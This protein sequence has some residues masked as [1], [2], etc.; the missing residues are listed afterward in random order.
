MK[1]GLVYPPSLCRVN[2][3]FLLPGI[4]LPA[5]ADTLRRA[6]H[7]AR[8]FDCDIRFHGTLRDPARRRDL[9]LLSDPRAVPAFLRG[10]PAPGTARRLAAWQDAVMGLVPWEPCGL[11]QITLDDLIGDLNLAALIARGLKER[12]AAPVSVDYSR[13]GRRLLRDLLRRYPVFDYAIWGNAQGPLLR[14]AEHLEGRRAPLFRTLARA[15][16]PAAAR[17]GRAA[18]PPGYGPDYSHPDY[19]GYPLA[20]YRVAPR[21]LLARYDIQPRLSRSLSKPG[22]GSG[23][24]LL[25]SYR[26][27]TTCRGACAFCD[28]DPARPSDRRGV[29]RIVSD[30]LALR[31][32]GATGIVFRNPS[33]NND[34]RFADALCDA[35]IEARLG[36]PWSDYANLR[37]LDE[38]LL[39]K[40]R[41]AGAVRLDFGMETASNRLLRYIRKGITRQNAERYLRLSHKLGI[42]NQVNLIGGF[43]TETDTDVRETTEFLRRNSDCIDTYALNPFYLYPESPFYRQARRFG[44]RPLPPAP[45]PECLSADARAGYVTERFDEIGGLDWRQKDAQIRRS[46]QLL[47]QTIAQTSSFGAID[48][49]HLHLLMHLYRRLGHAQKGLI[50][51]I[52]LRCTRQFRPYHMPGFYQCDG[53]AKRNYTRLAGPR[54]QPE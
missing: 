20:E 43:P 18:D 23:P 29:A 54:P 37:E 26:F 48:Q 28:N 9:A 17:E 3:C 34:Y 46:T 19:A 8:F 2:E 16:T 4:A 47:A 14:L 33:F 53:Y 36:L 13:L 7:A 45:R 15:G 21:D 41:R 50:R 42:W 51:E 22:A 5:M 10:Q 6:G 31:R 11:Y 25:V 52:F 30:L 39:R 32:L 44:I 38:R 35:M 27:E 49:E 24:E 12:F 1:V 40:M